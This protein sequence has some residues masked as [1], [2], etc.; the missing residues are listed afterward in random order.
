MIINETKTFKRTND[1]HRLTTALSPILKSSEELSL[2][3]KIKSYTSIDK[4]SSVKTPT[5]DYKIY[6]IREIVSQIKLKNKN[7]IEPVTTLINKILTVP[8]DTKK[9]QETVTNYTQTAHNETKRAET[10]T[11]NEQLDN[12]NKEITTNKSQNDEAIETSLTNEFFD[13]RNYKENTIKKKVKEL[14]NSNEKSKLKCI[15]LDY[16]DNK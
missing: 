2:L 16:N 12:H 14:L 4:A 3:E 6:N 1:I 13:F 9:V 11:I 5:E 8:S 15:L 7:S 10:Q